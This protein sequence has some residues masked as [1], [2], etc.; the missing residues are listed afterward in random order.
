V[1]QVSGTFLETGDVEL[2]AVVTEKNGAVHHPSLILWED[3]RGPAF[4]GECDCGAG[5]N[6]RHAAAL[7]LHLTK[8]KGARVARAFGE[9]PLADRMTG[10]A[11]LDLPPMDAPKRVESATE[12]SPGATLFPSP[13]PSA[14]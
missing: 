5:T 6:C 9:A 13:R 14:P 1:D 8:G 12:P 4:E 3:A 2:R 11:A 7:L 10:T